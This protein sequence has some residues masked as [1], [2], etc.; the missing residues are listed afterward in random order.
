MTNKFIEQVY[1]RLDN[2][3]SL[4]ILNEDLERFYLE[5]NA[6]KLYRIYVLTNKNQKYSAYYN[7]Y[8]YLLLCT[9][10]FLEGKNN[11]F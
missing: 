7:Y 2:R 9:D 8:L 4:D 11:V 10:P 5:E 3:I 6:K 1:M